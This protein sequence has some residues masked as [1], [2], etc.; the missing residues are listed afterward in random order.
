MKDNKTKIKKGGNDAGRERRKTGS[1]KF[2]VI[3]VIVTTLILSATLCIAS[4][5]NTAQQEQG[6]RSEYPKGWK[7]SFDR[8][9]A[10]RQKTVEEYKKQQE[11]SKR[12]QEE[13]GKQLERYEKFLERGEKQQDKTE[14]QQKRFDR[15]LS[16]WENQQKQYQEYLNSLRKN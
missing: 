1:S 16:V 3:F 6:A 5:K 10:E 14:E 2:P 7:E 13:Y 12:Q 8:V 9:Q 11:E 4:E 15:I